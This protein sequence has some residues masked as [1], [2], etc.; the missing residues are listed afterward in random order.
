[1]KKFVLFFLLANASASITVGGEA[2]YL[3]PCTP[4]FNYAVSNTSPTQIGH[5]ISPMYMWGYRIFGKAKYCHHS[6]GIFYTSFDNT[7]TAST[8][9]N[10]FIPLLLTGNLFDRALARLK[11]HYRT[12]DIRANLFLY[13][14]YWVRF[15]LTIGIDYLHFRRTRQIIATSSF[16]EIYRFKGTGPGVG[17]YIESCNLGGFR[18]HAL[19]TTTALIGNQ[20]MRSTVDMG[21]VLDRRRQTTLLPAI[22]FK[23][24]ASYTLPLGC[25]DVGVEI[26]YEI[27]H[28]FQL[29]DEASLTFT[30]TGNRFKNT[31]ENFGLWG[32]YAR[33]FATF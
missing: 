22:Y 28:Y 2:L 25:A 11:F 12:F 3:K 7:T 1:M 5:A 10:L 19:L 21:L 16:D 23:A 18:C 17:F 26:G 9:D 31:K 32:P 6:I 30:T 24:G 4:V 8:R 13:Q 20:R 27:H 15:H 14:G 29:I 33:L